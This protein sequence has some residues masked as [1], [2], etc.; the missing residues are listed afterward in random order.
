MSRPIPNYLFHIPNS[1]KSPF[2]YW[3]LEKKVNSRHPPAHVDVI[4]NNTK[5]RMGSVPAWMALV[6]FR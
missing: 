6:K 4:D 3:T 5:K 1:G 2:D